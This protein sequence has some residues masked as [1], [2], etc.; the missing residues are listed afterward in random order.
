[1]MVDDLGGTHDLKVVISPAMPRF[2]SAIP[3][4]E[5]EGQIAWMGTIV[6]IGAALLIAVFLG[7]ATQPEASRPEKRT[8]SI[9]SD[10]GVGLPTKS[11]REFPVRAA[12][13]MTRWI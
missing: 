7:I 5:E 8:G 12:G 6:I 9:R 1:M 2:D 10:S 13:R 3:F 4:L 11:I